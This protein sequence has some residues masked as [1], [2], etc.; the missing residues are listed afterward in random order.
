[1]EYCWPLIVPDAIIIRTSEIF[2]DPSFPE[3]S[4]DLSPKRIADRAHYGFRLP[5][6]RQAVH[7]CTAIKIVNRG[8][9]G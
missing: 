8:I 4:D 7:A 5:A 2:S 3:K 1:M 9:A 6:A